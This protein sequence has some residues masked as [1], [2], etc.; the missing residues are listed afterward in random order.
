M[1]RSSNCDLFPR[2]AQS[3]PLPGSR[4]SS[5][6]REDS[7]QPPTPYLR[8]PE[9][10]SELFKATEPELDLG[11]LVDSQPR[12]LSLSPAPPGDTSLPHWSWLSDV[13]FSHSSQQCSTPFCRWTCGLGK[14]LN[15]SLPWASH[16]L[17]GMVIFALEHVPKG[18]REG[19]RAAPSTA[20]QCLLVSFHFTGLEGERAVVL[21]NH[22]VS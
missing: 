4:S 11:S 12:A 9:R 14:S 2:P 22:H 7:L 16:S 17:R 8:K 6:R 13:A 21:Q 20:P 3:Q 18:N 5:Q 10:L 15:F 19:G 1:P